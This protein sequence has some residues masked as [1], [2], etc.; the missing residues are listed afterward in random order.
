M[1]IPL[2]LVYSWR[3]SCHKTTTRLRRVERW[4]RDH[5]S[6]RDGRGRLYSELSR[7]RS[8][9][10]GPGGVVQMFYTPIIVVECRVD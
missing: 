9:R 4:A 3:V 10:P 1:E 7:P 8:P 5:P 6:G 2:L